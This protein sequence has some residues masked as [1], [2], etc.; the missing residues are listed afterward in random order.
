M[1]N[2]AIPFRPKLEGQFRKRFYNAVSEIKENTPASRVEAIIDKEIEWVEKEC[3]F[4]LVQRKKYRAIWLLFRDLYRASWKAYY[5]DGVFE[6]RLPSLDNSEVGETAT[7]EVKSLLRSW[8]QESRYERMLTYSDFIS[9][10]EMPTGNKK[11]ISILIADGNELADRMAAVV[12]GERTIEDAISPYLQLVRENERD[13]FSG[14]KLSDIW[15]YFRLTWSTPAE[16]TPGRTMQYLIRDA[17]HPKHA[18]VGIASL[19]NSA[20]QITCRDD[21]IGWTPSA[22]TEELK[23]EKDIE[24]IK[25]SFYRLLDYLEDGIQGIDFQD[26]CAEV[27][28]LYPTDETVRKLQG[29]AVTAEEERQNLLR[30]NRIEYNEAA[31]EKSELGSISRATENALYLR[32]RSEQLAKLLSAKKLLTEVLQGEAFEKSWQAFAESEAGYSAIRTALIAQKGKHI[33]SSIMELNVCGAIPPYN[34]ILGGKLVALLATS[35]QIVHDYRERYTDR[36]SEIASRLKNEDVCRAADLVYIGTTSLYY[37][38]SSQYNRL[39]IPRELFDAENDVK[40]KK[41]GMTIGFG[42]MHISKATTMSLTEA[43]N[44]IGFTRI[45]HVFGEG[46]SPKMRLLTMAIRELLET[47]QDD[48]RDFSKHAMSRI[49]YGAMLASNTKEYLLGLEDQPKFYFGEEDYKQGTEKIINYWQH[50]WVLSRLKYTPIFERIRGFDKQAFLVSSDIKKEAEWKFEKLKEVA[51]MQIPKTEQAGINFVRDFYRGSSGFAD[52]IDNAMLTKIHVIT[53]LDEAILSAVNEGKDVILTGNP[54]DGKTHIIRMLKPQFDA[55]SKQPVVELD[56]STLTNK[57]IYERWRTANCEGR[58]FIIAINAAV[59]FSLAYEFKEFKA[60]TS[61]RE[62][63]VH[64]TVFHDEGS[65]TDDIVVYDLSKREILVPSIVKR[66]IEKLTAK[67][68]FSECEGC[69]FQYACEAVKNANLLQSELFQK[70]L[71]II[72]SRVALQGHHAT[73]RELQAF[74]AYLIFGNRTCEEISSTAGE[75]RYE[76]AN[77]IYSGEGL[78]FDAIRQSF[79]PAR[80][81]HPHWDELLLSNTI[82]KDS[83]E[84]NLTIADEAIDPSNSELFKLRKRQFYYFNQNGEALM[85]LSDDDVSRFQGFLKQDDK[86]AIKEMIRKLNAFFGNTKPG[87]EFE[88]WSGHRYNNSPRRVLLSIGKM[89][90]SQFA[91]GRPTL[92]KEMQRGIQASQDYVRLEKKGASGI[93]LKVDF[94]LYC[95]LLKAERGVPVLFLETDNVKKVWRFVEQ[96]Q[97]NDQLKDEDEITVTLLDVQ[98]KREI[99]VAI[100]RDGKRYLSIQNS[101]NHF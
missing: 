49:V 22:F 15:R 82:E 96:L 45:N 11:S 64:S 86:K 34:E 95:L 53:E 101:K 13:D 80:V 77:L 12:A 31:E 98:A 25:K 44:D 88:I 75:N 57:E 2:R 60:V 10:M 24:A 21:A 28:L 41:L 43:T 40:W 35:P 72:L 79:D 42:T 4:N 93:F 47:N 83:W 85:A 61:A 65:K 29:I 36:R 46:A 90:A 84:R 33:G 56:A 63:M 7:P 91:I 87:A 19:E 50:R 52:Y 9:R 78:L 14:L 30:I 73:L 18:V 68:N 94:Q 17:A 27:E 99:S 69:H 5:H 1:S 54:G 62:Q 76:L 89:T 51:N 92:C 3:T 48:T 38:G 26:L 66:A 100:D 70:R 74:I 55:M 97:A 16:T 58:P 23:K 81:S 20:V 37:V 39:K 59:L 71:A 32:K 8:M 6:M 67:H